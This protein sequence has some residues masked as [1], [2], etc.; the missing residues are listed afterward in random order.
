MHSAVVPLRITYTANNILW[1]N[2][3]SS[4]VRLCR[5]LRISWEKE[6]K[7][8]TQREYNRLKNEIDN[9]DLSI[10]IIRKLFIKQL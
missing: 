2:P 5:P 9:L 6:D 1:Q 8:T 3:N 10:I 7:E 4:S